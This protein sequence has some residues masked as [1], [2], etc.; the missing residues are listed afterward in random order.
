MLTQSWNSSESPADQT[1]ANCF[2]WQ[3][4]EKGEGAKH[5]EHKDSCGANEHHFSRAENR[6]PLFVAIHHN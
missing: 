3:E 5:S 6:A 4:M 1:T 2:V